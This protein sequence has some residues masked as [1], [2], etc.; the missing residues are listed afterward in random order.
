MTPSVSPQN[1]L[2]DCAIFAAAVFAAMALILRTSMGAAAWGDSGHG[3]LQRGA[4][5]QTSTRRGRLQP[6]RVSALDECALALN[7][8]GHPYPVPAQRG[9]GHHY[10]F[11]LKMAIQP[12]AAVG[13]PTLI[14]VHR[15][16]QSVGSNCGAG[17]PAA[18][19]GRKIWFV[20]GSA[21]TECIVR[22]LPDG[23]CRWRC[24]APRSITEWSKRNRA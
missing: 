14:L 11:R 2:I 23:Q 9:N 19:I 5:R 24:S 1:A 13:V 21:A 17:P 10:C 18:G 16:T 22:G 7:V 3:T 12:V 4:E 6:R 15:T 8:A 20:F